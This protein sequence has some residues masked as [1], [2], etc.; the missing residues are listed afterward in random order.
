MEINE[1]TTAVVTGGG[2]GLGAAAAT[3]LAAL[4]ATVAVLDRDEVAAKKTADAN[5]ERM[6]PVGVDV[7]DEDSVSAAFEVIG[8]RFDHINIL[9]S[10]AGVAPA[11]KVVSGGKPLPMKD[12]R[13]AIEVNLIGLFDVLRRC[14]ALMTASAPGPEGERGVIVNVSSGAAF[15]GMKGQASYSAS[16][17]GVIGLMLPVARDLARHGIRVVTISPGLFETGMSA[18][19]T[20]EVV[21]E[22]SERIL[23]P[24]RL[25]NPE[26]FAGIVTHIVENRY[27]NAT[28]LSLDAGAR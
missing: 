22:V 2:S 5:P 18:G 27:L 3:R 25:G 16:K 20:P 10:A 8:A 24:A 21:A 7:A 6:F 19:F 11:G 15:Q 23:Y 12:F 9:V 28:T 13:S 26:E 14:A 4:G 1:T 17:A